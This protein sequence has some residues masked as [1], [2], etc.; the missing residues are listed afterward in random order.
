MI[1]VLKE[2][3]FNHKGSLLSITD[4][5]GKIIFANEQFCQTSQYELSELIGQ[6][7]RL[8]NS[9]FHSKDFFV[10]L[11]QTIC[12]GR[13]WKGEI[14]NKSKDGNLYWVETTISPVFDAQGKIMQFVSNRFLINEQSVRN[15]LVN[16]AAFEMINNSHEFICNHDL[17]GRILAVNSAATKML[18]FSEEQLC[19]LNLKDLVIAPDQERLRAYLET[20]ATKK[21]AKGMLRVAHSTGRIVY[22]D[23]NNTLR[24]QGFGNGMVSW[25]AHDITSQ[26]EADE[27][28]RKNSILLDDA[29]RIAKMGSWE[30][31]MTTGQLHF[32]KEMYAIFDL[33]PD[34]KDMRFGALWQR[35]CADGRQELRRRMRSFLV[36]NKLSAFE[37]CI[38]DQQ[39]VKK[40]LMG[41]AELV[42]DKQG[43]QIKAFGIAQDITELKLAQMTLQEHK[44]MLESIYESSP[45]A[46]IMISRDGK[47]NG[48]DEK[49]KA[50]FGWSE[51]EVIGKNLRFLFL[52]EESQAAVLDAFQKAAKALSK[53]SGNI[54][55]TGVDKNGQAS[56]LLLSFVTQIINGN[57]RILLFARDL[58][59]IKKTQRALD[60]Q[61]YFTE[62]ILNNIPADV[63]VFNAQHQYIFVNPKGIRD[64]KL[65]KWM[66]GKD[67]FDY[68]KLKNSSTEI[69][70]RR[71][72]LFN[73]VV[74]TQIDA[75]WIDEHKTEDGSSIF[76]YRR[77]H[78]FI[79][80]DNEQFV[81][82]YGVDV[83][84]LKKKEKE[85]DSMVMELNGR[86]NEL[87]Q[88]NYIVSH[89]LRAPIANIIGLS[90]ML[91]MPN[92]TDKDKNQVIDYIYASVV[93][94][95]DMVKDLAVIL[96]SRTAL[97]EKRE[98]VNLKELLTSICGTLDLQ[99]RESKSILN[100]NFAEDAKT[101]I[102]I[103]SYLESILYNL[104][105]NAIKYKSELRPPLIRISSFIEDEK[106]V[107]RVSDNGRGI[108][109]AKQGEYVFGLYKRF[110][111]DVEGKGL[112]LHMTKSQVETIGGT[113]EIESAVEQG[114]TFTI[115]IPIR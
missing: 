64:P 65:R 36:S 48:W 97:N 57:L 15:D 89:N 106:L 62:D 56:D 77:Y 88:F 12:S 79:S 49:A 45:D 93:K 3:T 80:P 31:D 76:V 109:L 19:K 103:R 95:D 43:K 33:K 30:L 53:S 22:L 44:S 18:G 20:I 84:E 14:C 10:N 55:A 99:I 47:I 16:G 41:Q 74:S 46:A 61:R 81:M 105:S 13:E 100:I 73:Q 78:P 85:L 86:Y 112:G 92:V 27:Q 51:S 9:G 11:W 7:H 6:D 113:I 67:D 102:T 17:Q 115:K 114:T 108:D 32:S 26:M 39:G 1:K 40:Y 34:E 98:L 87:M 37:F 24:D 29:Q 111:H 25:I 63:A 21:V 4:P 38:R 58:S 70:E 110:H 60:F 28:L 42:R 107:L 72:A 91:K 52:E 68:A 94:M 96:S 50:L 101:I 66:I 8:F 2:I 104:V 69:A 59:A 71:R 83:T 75:E 35:I 90:R 5:K 54:E 82:G 23:Y